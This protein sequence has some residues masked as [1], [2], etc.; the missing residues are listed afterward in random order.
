MMIFMRLLLVAAMLAFVVLS[1]AKAVGRPS[2]A[3]GAGLDASIEPCTSAEIA[4]SAT[5]PRVER[6]S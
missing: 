5:L 4:R 1:L 2:V 6:P 3:D